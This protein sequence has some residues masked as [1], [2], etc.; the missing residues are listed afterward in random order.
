MAKSSPE[1]MLAKSNA[2][3]SSGQ[4]S[5]GN[6]LGTNISLKVKQLCVGTKELKFPDTWTQYT[7]IRAL[8]IRENNYL[9]T[10]NYY[11]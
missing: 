10:F 8:C 6:V 11:L 1:D 9:G 5:V 2:R 7:L 4:A 3:I